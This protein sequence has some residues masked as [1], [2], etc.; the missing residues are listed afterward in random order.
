M[1]S[2][3][4]QL[5]G[6]GGRCRR[7]SRPPPFEAPKAALLMTRADDDDDECGIANAKVQ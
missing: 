1:P 4:P 6:C 5:A 2:G 7:T 3:G